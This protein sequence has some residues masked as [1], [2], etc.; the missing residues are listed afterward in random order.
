[1]ALS[2]DNLEK[3]VEHKENWLF[4]LVSS[5]SAEDWEDV[6]EDWESEVDFWEG[7]RESVYLAYQDYH[8][9]TRLYHG[10]IKKHITIS[11]S[12]DLENQKATTSGFTLSIVD[13]DLSGVPL[14]QELFGGL[15]SYQNQEVIVSIRVSKETIEIGRFRMMN[16]SFDGHTISIS[17]QSARPW[18]DVMIPQ[19]RDSSDVLIPLVYGLFRKNDTPSV[20]ADARYYSKTQPYLLRPIPLSPNI[21]IDDLSSGFVGLE[22]ALTHYYIGGYNPSKISGSHNADNYQMSLYKYD[23][24]L[25]AFIQLETNGAFQTTL[26]GNLEILDAIVN[27]RN[28]YYLMD[29]DYILNPKLRLTS[30]FK[31]K[32]SGARKVAGGGTL[33]NIGNAIDLEQDYLTSTPTS[34]PH[35]TNHA[36]LTFT[37]I[38]QTTSSANETAIIE[39]TL[40]P[41][42]GELLTNQVKFSIYYTAGVS[43]A[44]PTMTNTANFNVSYKWDTSAPTGVSSSGYTSLISGSDAGQVGDVE[45]ESSTFINDVVLSGATEDTFEQTGS[46]TKEHKLY[47]RFNTS[48]NDSTGLAGYTGFYK[49]KDIRFQ[50]STGSR[51]SKPEK[52][53]YTSMRGEQSSVTTADTL[54]GASNESFNGPDAHRDLLMRFTNMSNS[55]PI[56][57]TDLQSSRDTNGWDLQYNTLEQVSLKSVLDLIQ[58]EHAFIFR[59][60]QGDISKPQYIFVKDSYSSSDYTVLSKEDISRPNLSITPFS[61][62]TTKLIINHLKHPA[63]NDFIRTTESEVSGVRDDLNIGSRENIKTIDLETLIP[64]FSS[65]S[66]SYVETSGVTYTGTTPN[67]SYADYYLNLFGE[68]K[69]LIDFLLVNPRYNDLEV[70]DVLQFDNSNM[71]PKK[72]FGLSSWSGINFMITDTRKKLGSIKI[73]ARQI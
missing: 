54:S 36:L 13:F 5:Y 45:A 63:R 30:S 24:G 6:S 17:C 37:G 48:S 18:D 56:G 26:S 73:S 62:L 42:D 9:G 7:R 21:N 19:D 34:E 44:D 55:T 11:E 41:F 23:S 53:L 66:P 2:S 67:K 70:G 16:I 50:I 57:F 38:S 72:P 25:D 3:V 68:P 39:F 28:V 71:F 52:V 14:S 1:M 33:L 31:T 60:K 29:M 32:P 35:D 65:V 40:P 10:A 4:E 51:I 58:K 47:L 59:Y 46:L 64:T 61:S 12:I 49:I 27:S 8:D 20:N 15:N 43:L 22:D 69:L